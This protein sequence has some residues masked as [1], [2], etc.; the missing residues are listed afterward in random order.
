ME[1]ATAEILVSSTRR[2]EEND[3][4]V[5][6]INSALGGSE[7]LSK[8]NYVEAIG[9]LEDGGLKS[10]QYI[11]GCFTGL[12]LKLPQYI[13]LFPTE[14]D[15]YFSDDTSRL[16]VLLPFSTL[17]DSLVFLQ[18]QLERYIEDEI[19]SQSFEYSV[20]IQIEQ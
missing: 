3:V 9:N 18:S 12:L 13:P 11:L 8:A 10:R 7:T 2:H 17:E 5:D 1:Y 15:F 4:L 20:N 6:V 19:L 14:E 16:R